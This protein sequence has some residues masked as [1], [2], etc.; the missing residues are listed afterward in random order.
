[1]RLTLSQRLWLKLIP[2]LR[3]SIDHH[4]LA[5]CSR[6]QMANLDGTE[7]FRNTISLKMLLK[8]DA[9]GLIEIAQTAPSR[10][11]VRL[12]GRAKDAEQPAALAVQDATDGGRSELDRVLW[13]W[14]SRLPA[15]GQNLTSERRAEINA[16]FASVVNA[17]Y[18][19]PGEP[20]RLAQEQGDDA[21][22]QCFEIPIPGKSGFKIVAPSALNAD[23]W[24]MLQHMIAMYI[25]RWKNLKQ[26]TAS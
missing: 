4:S 14:L 13:L 22:G 9:L 12:S 15:P 19:E 18:P 23:D 20:K 17:A 26:T 21:G 11:E 3:I 5:A 10:W 1:M 7:C 25:E 24:E 2:Q 8:L 16:A 6:I